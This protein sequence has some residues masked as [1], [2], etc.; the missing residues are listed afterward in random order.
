MPLILIVD[1]SPTE[2]HQM[3]RVLQQHGYQTIGANDGASAVGDWQHVDS[4]VY[5][6]LFPVLLFHS[7]VKSPLDLGAA[8]SMV[9]AG[10]CL[11]GSGI[12][13]ANQFIYVV[14]MSSLASVIGY[15]ELTRNFVT[16]QV[17]AVGLAERVRHVPG[18]LGR[19]PRLALGEV[20][21]PP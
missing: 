17:V 15:Q 5:Y 10:L 3:Q 13:L 9:G 19:E 2:L 14:K 1:D 4:L 21:D 20:V 6:F 12:A 8:S 18:L 11:A 7:I 16:D